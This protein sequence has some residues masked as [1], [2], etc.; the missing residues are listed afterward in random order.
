MAAKRTEQDESNKAVAPPGKAPAARYKVQRD[1]DRKVGEVAWDTRRSKTSEGGK[2]GAK[3]FR[4]QRRVE[5]VSID[6]KCEERRA[7]GREKRGAEC[8]Q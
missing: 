2:V 5:S 4:K 6:R 1:E 7:V 3:L 8:C